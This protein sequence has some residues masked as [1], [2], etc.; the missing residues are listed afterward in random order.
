MPATLYG[1]GRHVFRS[2]SLEILL[3]LL[4]LT[5]DNASATKMGGPHELMQERKFK[6]A[7]PHSR[8]LRGAIRDSHVASPSSTTTFANNN[9]T[10]QEPVRTMKLGASQLDDIAQRQTDLTGVTR[11][12]AQIQECRASSE[13]SSAWSCAKA[14]DGDMNT[15]WGTNGEGLCSWITLNFGK[16]VEIN[17]LA[18]ANRIAEERNKDI[19][20]EFSDGSVEAVT[21]RNDSNLNS[22][23]FAE[24]TSSFVKIHVKSTYSTMNNGAREIQFWFINYSDCSDAVVV[25]GADRHQRSRMGTYTRVDV[26]QEVEQAGRTIYQSKDGR[27]FLYYWSPHGAWRIGADYRS[28]D[29]G[30]MSSSWQNT[31][32]ATQPT[33]W[34]MYAETKWISSSITVTRKS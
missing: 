2:V 17:T 33:S 19:Q 27:H 3:S 31:N 1:C 32:C 24:K 15:Q 21:L 20:L 12:Q 11:T 4:L 18:Y 34:F 25:K 28:A 23:H 8:Q 5:L 14:F 9:L 22:Y 30:V 29:A 16:P 6:F 26:P 7:A 10:S 13:Y